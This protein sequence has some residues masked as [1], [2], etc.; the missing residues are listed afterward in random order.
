LLDGGAGAEHQRAGRRSGVEF[1]DTALG[2][3]RDPSGHP[4]IAAEAKMTN[5]RLAITFNR[6]K[7]A[8]DI[9]YEVQAAG[10]VF[11]FSNATVLWSSA[12]NAYGAGTNS[13]EAVTVQDS[14]NAATTNRRFMRLQVSRP[15]GPGL[16]LRA[17]PSKLSAHGGSQRTHP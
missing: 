1:V 4:R 3:N 9:V 14:I 2:L 8:T 5:S 10:I 16:L 15:S 7:S 13:S 12:S 6:Q 11:G 17:F